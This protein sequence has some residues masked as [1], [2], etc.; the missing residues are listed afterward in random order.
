MQLS[1]HEAVVTA[2]SV[3]FLAHLTGLRRV[4]LEWRLLGYAV[5]VA[6]IMAVE[7]IVWAGIH[8]YA[9]WDQPGEGARGARRAVAARD[10]ARALPRE[11]APETAPRRATSDV[12]VVGEGIV[13]WRRP[14]PPRERDRT[15]RAGA[16]STPDA[17]GHG[18]PHAHRSAAAEVTVPSP[19]SEA[20][21]EAEEGRSEQGMLR[22][23]RWPGDG[24]APRAAA[25]SGAHTGAGGREEPARRKG[26]GEAKE[27]GEGEVEGEALPSAWPRA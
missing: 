23:R 20:V 7:A 6:Y 16:A 15:S 13:G 22:Q 9:R 3:R 21:A 4:M 14:S 1:T 2:A 25:H 12:R 19:P 10:G 26:E 11:A 24:G 18:S 27:E 17:R 8:L 5:G